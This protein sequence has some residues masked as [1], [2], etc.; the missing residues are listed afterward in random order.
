MSEF[1]IRPIVAAPEAVSSLAAMLIETVAHGGSVSFMHPLAQAEAEAFWRGSLAAATRGERVVLGAYR[2]AETGTEI[3][4]D[5]PG[6]CPSP[7]EVRAD[8]GEAPTS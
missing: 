5:T 4:L 1:A 8:E 3:T 2:S 7:C 6:I